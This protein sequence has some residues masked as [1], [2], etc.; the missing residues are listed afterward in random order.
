MSVLI[1]FFLAGVALA[2]MPGRRALWVL[3]ACVA[4]II[5]GAVSMDAEALGYLLYIGFFM[6]G[7]TVVGF[8]FGLIGKLG[9]WS[10]SR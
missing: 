8:S 10:F 9:Y 5:L 4:A 7:A 1:Y 6:M 2:L 3:A